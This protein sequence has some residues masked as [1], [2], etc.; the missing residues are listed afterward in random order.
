MSDDGGQVYP[1]TETH[2]SCGTRHHPGKSLRDEFAGQIAAAMISAVHSWQDDAL[3]NVAEISY[4]MAQNL[5][6]EKRKRD[7]E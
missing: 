7:A 2:P 3:K 1:I 4:D 5:I 6:N